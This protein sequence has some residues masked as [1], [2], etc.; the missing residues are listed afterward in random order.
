MKKLVKANGNVITK[1]GSVSDQSD[2]HDADNDCDSGIGSYDSEA[3]LSNCSSPVV[4][5]NN[6]DDQQGRKQGRPSSPEFALAE[7]SR[8]SPIKRSF[9]E[10][11]RPGIKPYVCHSCSCGFSEVSSLRA[12]A[13]HAHPRKGIIFGDYTCG[14]CLQHYSTTEPLEL[15][16]ETHRFP[17]TATFSDNSCSPNR[18]S[19]TDDPKSKMS[20]KSLAFSIENICANSNQNPSSTQVCHERSSLTSSSIHEP[21]LRPF[22]IPSIPVT[23]QSPKGFTSPHSSGRFFKSHVSAFCQCHLDMCHLQIH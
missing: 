23:C 18:N 16:V 8:R 13:R 20:A 2:C 6:Y 7:K 21:I 17:K 19:C 11:Q 10:L 22:L 9:S 14:F 12:H 5:D 4:Q 15:H 1:H 3:E